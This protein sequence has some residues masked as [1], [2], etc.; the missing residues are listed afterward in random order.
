M[1]TTSNSRTAIVTASVMIHSSWETC[2]YGASGRQNAR[3]L[4]RRPLGPRAGRPMTAD[5]MTTPRRRNT[6]LAMQSVRK[7]CAMPTQESSRRCATMPR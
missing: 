2:I 3:G 6:P 4:F 1:T 5:V 7:L